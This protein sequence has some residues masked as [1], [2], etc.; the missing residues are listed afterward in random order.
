[1]EATNHGNKRNI[2]D[3]LKGLNLPN[4][5]YRFLREGGDI[6]IPSLDIFISLDKGE[7]LIFQ[8]LILN[9]KSQKSTINLLAKKLNEKEEKSQIRIINFLNEVRRFSK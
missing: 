8:N 4:Y 2:D 9:K 7:S 1:M 5:K 3:L 6:F